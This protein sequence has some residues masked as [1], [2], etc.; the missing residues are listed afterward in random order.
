MSMLEEITPA[1]RKVMT[2]FYVID[3]SE[4]MA[5]SRIGTVNSAMEECRDLLK[6]L[7]KANA[8]A[9]IKVAVMQF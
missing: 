4:S 7:A 2:L 9:E 6:E 5:G 1:P 3:T 8:D